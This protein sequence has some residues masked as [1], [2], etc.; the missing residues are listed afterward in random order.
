MG[1]ACTAV[2]SD[3]AA[4]AADAPLYLDEASDPRWHSLSTQAWVQLG[5]LTKRLTTLLNGLV[6][7]QAVAGSRGHRATDADF[8]GT[9]AGASAKKALVDDAN[10][11]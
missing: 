3:L 5:R 10:H 6:A 2:A 1:H 9:S 4:E 8:T 7:L 11:H